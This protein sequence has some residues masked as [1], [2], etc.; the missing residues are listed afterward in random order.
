MAAPLDYLATNAANWDARAD[1]HVGPDGYDLAR[2]ADPQWISQVVQFDRPRLGEVAG[3]DAVH[4]QCHV[5]T[6]TISLARLGATMT[7]VDLSGRCPHC[8]HHRRAR[9][10]PGRLRPGRRVLRRRGAGGA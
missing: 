5:G 7:G 9:R 1:V 2:I 4:L 10:G 6:D 3:L 8:P